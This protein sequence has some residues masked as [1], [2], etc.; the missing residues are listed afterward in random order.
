ML[1]KYLFLLNAVNSSCSGI[2]IEAENS[3]TFTLHDEDRQSSLISLLN[4]NWNLVG[5]LF[6]R[7]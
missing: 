2:L 5:N 1:D 7:T 6:A 3:V 4:N